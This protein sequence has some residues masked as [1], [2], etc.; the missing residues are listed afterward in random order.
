MHA[1][2]RRYHQNILKVLRNKLLHLIARNT[3]SNRLRIFLFRLSGAKIAKSSFIGIETFLDDQFPQYIKI[4]KGCVL[5]FRVNLVVH[6]MSGYLKPITFKRNSYAGCASTILPGVIVGENSFIA[7][8]SVVT[9]DVPPN[10]IVAGVP[11]R[12]IK[13]TEP[14]HNVKV[15]K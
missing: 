15:F 10:T 12:V 2:I 9:K 3:I 4:G 11:A 6:D 8:G 13:Q 7:A 5:S 1:P 14:R